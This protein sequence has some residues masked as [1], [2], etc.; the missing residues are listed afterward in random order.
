MKR[1]LLLALITLV[2]IVTVGVGTTLALVISSSG[3]V[4]N[5]FTV[6][7]VDITLT[8]TL[9]RTTQLVPGTRVTKDP[10][11]TVKA[12]S[13]NCYLFVELEHHG[14]HDSYIYYEIAEGWT[15]LGGFPGVYYREVKKAEVDQRYNV[16]KDNQVRISQYLTKEKMKEI[17]ADHG[18]LVITAYAIQTYSMESASDGW[19][20]LIA[21]IGKES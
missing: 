1:K 10:T 5:T 13:E 20:R 19:Y 2:C 3:P 11:V 6:G 7:A 14:D 16:L 4:K 18:G 15:L 9:G 21:E 17:T 8:E 12:G